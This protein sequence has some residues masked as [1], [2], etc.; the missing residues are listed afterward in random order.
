MLRNSIVKMGSAALC[1]VWLYGCGTP[2]QPLENDPLPVV[3]EKEVPAFGT[4]TLI[5][6]EPEPTAD[7]VLVYGNQ[8]LLAVVG[9]QSFATLPFPNGGMVLTLDWQDTP[10]KFEEVIEL[11]TAFVT[12]KFLTISHKFD[13]PEIA[14]TEDATDYTMEETLILFELPERFATNVLQKLDPEYSYVFPPDE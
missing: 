4:L 10:M 14:K 3:V 12:N 1:G 7:E 13:V 11:D 5:R 9:N 2:V 6:T 8:K